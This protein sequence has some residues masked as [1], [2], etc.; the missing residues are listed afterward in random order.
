MG[1]FATYSRRSVPAGAI[2]SSGGDDR[3][4]S[5]RWRES[6]RFEAVVERVVAGQD[7][8][9]ACSVVGRELARD[10]ADLGEA[11]D[12]LRATWARA[13]G[14]E[15]DFRAL[16]ALCVAWGEET[17]G[18]VH[19]ISCEDPLTGL[20]SRGHLRA[21]LSEVARAAGQGESS[22]ATSHALVVLD[23]PL[24]AAADD[25]DPFG[26]ALRLVRL[27]ETV[28]LVFP[29]DEVLAQVAPTRLVALVE[30]GPLLARRVGLLRGLVEDLDAGPVRIW[31]EG[32]PGSDDAAG[33][34]LDEIAR[35]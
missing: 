19:Q 5:V 10:G 7:A 21:R 32:L 34:L 6:A 12:G 33:W 1:I 22:A 26:P 25:Q 3:S 16:R 11:L 30:R 14:G 31:I 15:P 4:D 18:F 17:L 9:A 27:T 8:S 13:V 29:G 2:T 28:R 20:A 35:G 23:L 24:L